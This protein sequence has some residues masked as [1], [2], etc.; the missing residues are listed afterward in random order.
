MKEIQNSIGFTQGLIVP[1]EGRSGGLALLWKPETY[2][3]IK[4]YSKWYIDAEV[5]CRNVQGCWRFT[6]FYGQPDTNKREETWQI[7]EAFGR[8]NTLPWLCIGDYNE[9]LCNSEKLGG[10]FRPE[11]QMDRFREVVDVC[12]FRDSGFL[13]ARYTWSR[14]FENGDSVW[15]RL[16]CALANE[17]W[18]RKFANAKVVHIS[19]IES[20]HC[21]LCLQ[22][23]RDTSLRMRQGKLFRFEAMWLR[24][25][26]CPKVVS[27][28]WER[29]LSFHRDFP[30][31][32]CLQACR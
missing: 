2:V 18:M 15:A 27:E 32:N 7:L 5:V 30:I 11:R 26:S 29:G 4:G 19:S 3:S 21:M 6:G 13:G 14:H 17:E 12:Q 28:A 8:H 24:D 23:G 22:W 31:Q 20:D 1:S 25:P 16:D 10:Q 9:I